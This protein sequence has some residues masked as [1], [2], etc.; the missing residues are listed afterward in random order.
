MGKLISYYPPSKSTALAQMSGDA[1][2]D[3]IPLPKPSNPKPNPRPRKRKTKHSRGPARG[4]RVQTS[5]LTPACLPPLPHMLP[6]LFASP[7]KQESSK[8]TP[9]KMNRKAERN[10]TRTHSMNGRSRKRD[11]APCQTMSPGRTL[12][13]T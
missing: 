1:P 3:D 5:A 13:E 2:R 6:A 10:F 4:G 9:P 7:V 12:G 8:R 11:N